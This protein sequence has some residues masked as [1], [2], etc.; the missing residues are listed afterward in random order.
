[1]NIVLTG[2]KGSGK[3]TVA[4]D[5]AKQYGYEFID[6]DHVI[7]DKT[8]NKSISELYK[9]IGESEFRT[10]EQQA[11][12]TIMELV[13]GNPCCKYVIALGGGT[14]INP[15]NNNNIR[16]LGKIF[17]LSLSKNEL[18]NRIKHLDS[19]PELF[20]KNGVQSVDDPGFNQV[21]EQYYSSRE[22]IYSKRADFIID[23]S[24]KNIKE[25]SKLIIDNLC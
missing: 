12:F 10:L 20:K 23:T 19:L 3:T 18:I 2:F 17:Y 22:E 13:T 4:S 16:S 24:N 6:L 8:R 14:I 5:I 25:V 7:L 11:V 9:Q 1:M 15:S 21:F